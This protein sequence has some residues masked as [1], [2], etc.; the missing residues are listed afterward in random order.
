MKSALFVPP[1]SPILTRVA[2]PVDLSEIGTP[3]LDEIIATM[4]RVACGEQ[5]DRSV[6]VL[7][8]LAAPQIGFSKRIILVDDAADGRGKKGNLQAYINPQITWSSQRTTDWYEGCY[9]TSR[10]CGI[11]TRSHM[12]KFQA[13]DVSGKRVQRGFVG[14]AARIAKHE[15]DHLDGREFVN[16]VTDDNNLHWVEETEFPVYRDKEA[17]RDW[18]CKCSRARWLAIKNGTGT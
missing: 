10:V 4:F 3:E 18:P 5:A 14:Y 7:V 16:Y 8:G 2:V 6:P 15:L 13:L 1:H 12:V 9:S 11:V 17:W